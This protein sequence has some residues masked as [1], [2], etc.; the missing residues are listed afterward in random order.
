MDA[1]L[2]AIEQV[3][4]TLIDLALRFGPKFLVAMAILTAGFFA[5]SALQ[6]WLGR[7]LQRLELEPPVRELL[8]R[9][10]R[11][12]V[13]LLFVV[14][15]MQNL[16]IELLPLIA[17]LGVAGAGIA[18]AMQGLL[19]NVVA[20]LSIIFT[21]PFRVG[22]Y[23]S[24]VGEEGRV[25][26]ITIFSTT[27]SHPDRSVVVIPNRKV[28]GEILHN[29]G[30]TRQVSVVV[31][32]AYDTNLEHALA[33]I[34]KLLDADPRVLREPA[35]GVGVKSLGDSAIQLQISPWVSVADYGAVTGWLNGAVVELFRNENIS[36][37]FP[38]REVRQLALVAR[39]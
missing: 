14:M 36:I 22:E 33:S 5:S 17:G 19:G 9:V 18:L 13:M 39:G 23:I 12:F 3:R 20:G 10:A 11:L 16:G 25:E 27:L 35:A 29:Y 37:P 26:T 4:A 28:V 31:G 15:A 30:S 2:D 24:I 1:P 34:R 7:G 32:V 8:L 38:Q 6:S 21:K